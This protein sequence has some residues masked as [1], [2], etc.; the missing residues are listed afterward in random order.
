[1]SWIAT[2]VVG[3]AAIGYLGAS[4]AADAQSDAAQGAQDTERWKM[5]QQI[6]MSRPARDLEY[7]A[8]NFLGSGYV[9]G[10]HGLTTYEGKKIDRLNG[11]EMARMQPYERRLMNAANEQVQNAA[12]VQGSP[13]GGNA[14]SAI[15]RNTKDTLFAQRVPMMLQLAGLGGSQMGAAGIAG[16]QESAAIYAGGVGKANAKMAGYNALSGGLS[17]LVGA[18]VFGGGG[19]GVTTG[20]LQTQLNN[21]QNSPALQSMNPNYNIGL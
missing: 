5:R 12:G 6:N 17:D 8:L 14:L 3:S 9:P 10:Y 16:N 11:K 20:Q 2:A 21:L 18:G 19:G 13:I 15:S 1:M 7:G 4:K